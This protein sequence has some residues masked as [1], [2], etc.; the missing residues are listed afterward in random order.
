MAT[1]SRVT[2]LLCG[3]EASRALHEEPPYRVLRCGGCGLAFTD[4]RPDEKELA[5]LYTQGYFEKYIFPD[6][7]G[8]AAASRTAD[9]QVQILQM[10]KKSGT[11]LEIGCGHGNF[12]RA[13][14]NHG[15]RA[16]GVDIAPDAAR[17]V[18]K[19]H[20][21]PVAVGALESLGPLPGEPFDAVLMSHVLE[22]HRDP[23]AFLTHVRRRMAAGGVLWIVVPN[24]GRWGEWTGWSLPYHLYH[25]TGSTLKRVL[26]KSGFQTLAV[27]STLSSRV[28]KFNGLARRAPRVSEASPALAAPS[29]P[30]DIPVWKIRARWALGRLFPGSNLFAFATPRP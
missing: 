28:T 12:L 3:A 30:A 9:E 14:K 23:V 26:E 5:A 20:G 27:E 4:P 18:E 15:W 22:H 2:C 29:T 8:A 13:A 25:F 7:A 10:F 16:A 6:D 24:F 19:T 11:V 17:Y 21:L 1:Q